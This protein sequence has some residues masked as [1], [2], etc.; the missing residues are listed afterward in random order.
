MNSD[1]ISHDTTPKVPFVDLVAREERARRE[2]QM[3]RDMQRIQQQHFSNP[4]G[5][6]VVIIY[7]DKVANGGGEKLK[8]GVAHMG[9]EPRENTRPP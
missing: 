2:L 6:I 7:G 4:M 1:P 8:Y 5:S 3:L 9:D